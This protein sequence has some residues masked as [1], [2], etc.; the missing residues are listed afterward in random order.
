MA[1]R[2]ASQQTEL[3]PSNRICSLDY[4]Q[5]RELGSSRIDVA[6]DLYVIHF[7]TTPLI[8]CLVADRK[9]LFQSG[10]LVAQ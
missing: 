6:Y 7:A 2:I 3:L 4:G 5:G 1:C 10:W 8:L 9:R